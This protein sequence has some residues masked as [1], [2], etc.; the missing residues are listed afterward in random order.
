MS[1]AG[2]LLFAVCVRAQESRAAASTGESSPPDRSTDSARASSADVQALADTVHALQAQISALTTQIADLRAAQTQSDEQVRALQEQLRLAEAKTSST[3]PQEA[4]RSA[5]SVAIS[6]A[7][8]AA[9]QSYGAPPEPDISAT[10]MNSDQA[11]TSD[12]NQARSLADR[13]SDL[14]EG[15][16]LLNSKL[17]DQSQT[18]VESGSKYRVRLSGIVLLNLFENRGTVDT[19]DF[20]SLALESEQPFSSASFGGS[21]RQSQIG[22]EA[23]GPKI[24]GARTSASIDFDF[25]GG[26]PQN[27]VNGETMGILRLRTGVVRFDWQNTSLVA[28]QDFLF[29]SPLSPTSIT[30]LATPA[31]SYAGNLWS[32]TPQVRVEHRI[33]LSDKS[34]IM[35]QVGMLDSLSG[36]VQQP[37]NRQD[38]NPSWGEQSGQPAYAGRVAWTHALNNQNLTFGAG[39][40]YGRQFWGYGR[41]VDGWASMLDVSIPLTKMFSLTAEY[42]RGRAVAGLWGGIG[43][44]VLMSGSI[45]NPTSVIKG[46]DSMGGWI[47]LKFQPRENFQINAAYG[48][49]NP[50]AS[51]LDRF[52]NTHTYSGYLYAR[53]QSPLVNFI[54]QIRSDV[55]ISVEYRHLRTM[56][57]TDDTQSA[58]HYNATI[59]YKF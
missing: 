55:E 46:L 6:P 37:V 15:Q 48:Q 14:E 29:F 18:K 23:F 30:T 16:D 52:P 22:I 54:Y 26:F 58:N 49:D 1:A 3:A 2:L 20:P 39:G 43:Q 36:D 11:A 47:Q 10:P 7:A 35:L 32:W 44:D 33:P 42:Y 59:G 41:N 21:V 9:Q 50:F 17:I 38:A 24:R 53:N 4:P 40:Y 5:E 8:S 19:T 12:Q 27:T 51:E 57:L 34:S 13:V 45:F 56:Y 31:L 25:A 28:G